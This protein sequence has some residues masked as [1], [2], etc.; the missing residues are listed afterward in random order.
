MTSALRLSR[1]VTR[2][3]SLEETACRPSGAGSQGQC[4]PGLVAQG[5][6][7]PT[8]QGQ[9]DGCHP[10]AQLHLQR[11]SQQ[12]RGCLG[13]DQCKQET[14]TRRIPSW[15]QSVR[16]QCLPSTRNS[17]EKDEW[18]VLLNALHGYFILAFSPLFSAGGKKG[19]R[20]YKFKSS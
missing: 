8:Q 19:L 20:V 10:A 15:P 9:P 11:A 1:E 2:L 18:E 3:T 12:P 4:V 16:Q 17:K 7:G 14:Q 13:T 6:R 5:T